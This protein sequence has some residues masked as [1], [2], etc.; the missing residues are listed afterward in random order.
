MGSELNFKPK[1]FWQ[2]PEG[3]TG[4]LFLSAAIAGGAYFFYQALPTLVRL[5]E[6]TLY[7]SA[8]LAALAAALYVVLDP[9]MRNLIWYAYKSLM[10]GITGIFV[11]IDPM[12]ILRSYIASLEENLGKMTR[13]INQ[14]RGQMHQLKELIINNQKEAEQNLDLASRAKT[15][16]K[17]ADVVLKTR[18][19]GRLQDSNLRLDDLYR[20]ME[21]LYR[22]LSKMQENSHIMS[23]DLKDQIKMREIEYK[24]IT[25]SNSAMKSAMSILTGNNDKRQTFDMA[26]EAI[27]N[28][29]SGKVGEMERFMD[30]S[31]KFMKSIDLQNGIFEEE[32]LKM[33]EQWEKEGSSPLLG[34]AKGEIIEQ[35]NSDTLDL[36]TPP[37]MPIKEENHKNQ[38]DSF[39]D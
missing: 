4:A 26:M 34:K 22:V 35:R 8:M 25:A 33:L 9:R 20:R 28:D 15:L 13:Q 23:E 10:R 32:G 14:L 2:R 36:S 27:A 3:F 11:R 7:L 37:K 39:F 18:K 21:M 5:A 19:A 31:D 24:A 29:V 6:N 17:N 38:Y 12:S 1:S 30:M 16:G